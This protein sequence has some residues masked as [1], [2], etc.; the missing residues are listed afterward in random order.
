MSRNTASN[1]LRPAAR[2][3]A[4]AGSRVSANSPLVS[5]TADTGIDDATNVTSNGQISFA[6]LA[7]GD[8]REIYVN[9]VRMNMLPGTD[10]THTFTEAGTYTISVSVTA[11]DGT[12]T[13]EE[14]T[15]TLDV[16]PP[17]TATVSLI[18]DS[19]V[20]MTDLITNTVEL[21]VA[22][23]AAGDIIQYRVFGSSAEWITL[24]AG[25]GVF[26]P[27]FIDAGEYRID[28]RLIDLAG[29]ISATMTQL[30]VIYDPTAP[31]APTTVTLTADPDDAPEAITVSGFEDGATLQYRLAGGEWSSTPPA[32][33]ANGTYTV[34]VRA[35]DVAGNEGEPTAFEFSVDR[36]L[37]VTPVVTFADTGTNSSDGITNNGTVNVTTTIPDGSSL[38]F[39]SDGVTWTAA[40]PT[41]LVQGSNTVSARFVDANGN[42]SDP[43]ASVTFVLDTVI[44]DL[45]GLALD[46]IIAGATAGNSNVDLTISGT[47]TGAVIEYSVDAGTT[48]SQTAIDD[49][50][51]GTYTVLVHQIDIAGNVSVAAEL[52]VIV[53][54]SNERYDPTFY[55]QKTDCYSGLF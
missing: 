4:T 10:G 49:L 44:P 47:E 7:D 21:Q 1:Q 24:P 48:W 31:S 23:L 8:V 43:I 25:V 39:S 12:V 19:G 46:T 18:E 13:N 36:D 2:T 51:A 40:Q 37:P 16:L 33:L 17:A 41:D 20:S 42:A 35:I 5:L 38:E 9:K 32:N 26:Y 11:A 27:G 3:D 54:D 30:L 15:F 14:L 28:V 45:L 6:A 52:E 50:I 55:E 29:N 22:D 34:E 53:P